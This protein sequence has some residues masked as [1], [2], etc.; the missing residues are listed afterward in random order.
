M[1][2]IETT[3]RSKKLKFGQRKT[4]ESDYSESDIE[5]QR[6]QAKQL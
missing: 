6:K 3:T 5:E 2:Q 4:Y 1:R